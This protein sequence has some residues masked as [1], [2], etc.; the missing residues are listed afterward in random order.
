[1]RGGGKGDTAEKEGEDVKKEQKR[2]KAVGVG[3]VAK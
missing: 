3:G 1:M 2:M